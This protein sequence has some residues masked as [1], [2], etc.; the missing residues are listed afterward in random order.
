MPV[1]ICFQVDVW[2]PV[3]L[4]IMCGDDG[5]DIWMT[6]YFVFELGRL[7]KHFKTYKRKKW[8]AVPTIS[9]SV[10]LKFRLDVELPIWSRCISGLI[11]N[12]V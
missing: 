1:A 4:K 3:L 8:L 2:L 11:L 9:K 7:P 10:A 12:H 5:E 6:S